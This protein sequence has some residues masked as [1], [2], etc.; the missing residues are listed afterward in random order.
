MHIRVTDEDNERA[1]RSYTISVS[2]KNKNE[3]LVTNAVTKEGVVYKV[4]KMMNGETPSFNSKDSVLNTDMEEVNFS[5]F[6]K[7]EGLTYIKTNINDAN[8]TGDDFLSFDIDE[9]A[10][11]YV[12][13]EKLDNLKHLTIPAWLKEFKK[14][15]GEIWYSTVILMYTVKVLQKEK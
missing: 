3:I 7:Y 13:Y 11:I 2:E 9:N 14:E 6:D 5:R 10:V 8:K 4:S 12:A 1:T 15:D